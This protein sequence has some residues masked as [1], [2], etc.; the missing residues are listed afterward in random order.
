MAK[1]QGRE[2]VEEARAYRERVLGEL[3]RRRELARQQLEHL[4]HGRERLVQAFERARLVAVDVVAEM[5]PVDEPDEFVDLSP[6]TGPVPIMVPASR[7]GDESAIDE[8]VLRMPATDR[9]P[10]TTTPG[11]ER[12][13][14]VTV[15]DEP[16][17]EEPPT[18]LYDGA[19]DD[20]G[21]LAVDL[22]ESTSRSRTTRRTAPRTRSTWW[23]T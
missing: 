13:S 22:A 9:R 10:P 2:M 8:S 14:L 20:V 19:D 1:Q 16:E 17:V 11:A 15:D 4:V 12:L 5:T 18:I 6:T 3:S 7:V 21:G 23:T